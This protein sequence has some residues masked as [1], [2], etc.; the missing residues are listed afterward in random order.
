VN[1]RGDVRIIHYDRSR[2]DIISREYSSPC[3]ESII[4]YADAIRL[5]L[6]LAGIHDSADL[7][8]IFED[9][10]DIEASALLKT[11]LNDVEQKGFNTSTVRLLKEETIRH[12]AHAS[13]NSIRYDQMIDEIGAD[14]EPAVF[15]RA[16]I[17]LHHNVSAVS[18][19]QRRHKPNR[20]I[21]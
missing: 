17:L 18:I 13:Y 15:P 1:N 14:E 4:D 21:K 8:T 11:Q 19:N 6:K 10:T 12:L 3:A 5:K 20:L 7:M 16:N 9:R 2:P